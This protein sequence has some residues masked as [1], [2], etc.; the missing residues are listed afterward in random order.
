MEER[1]QNREPNVKC[2]Y[3]GKPFYKPMA[4]LRRK[5]KHHFCS[6]E[7]RSLW[8][9]GK[10]V[11]TEEFKKDL[12]Q[13]NK[14]RVWS[15]DVRLK[16]SKSKKGKSFL[17][18]LGRLAQSLQRKGRK[19]SPESIKKRSG[20]NHPFWKGGISYGEYPFEWTDSLKHKIRERDK[21]TCQICGKNGFVVHHIDY[22]KK[23]CNPNNL[24]TLCRKCHRKTNDNRNYW[25]KFFKNLKRKEKR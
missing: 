11:H 5:T 7:C 14:E 15:R 19:F 24:I 1:Y 21:F 23:N 10:K 6:V 13:R 9:Y 22:N 2:Y 20:K 17:T 8:N 18:D 3:C 16:S 4:Y 12:A 25:I